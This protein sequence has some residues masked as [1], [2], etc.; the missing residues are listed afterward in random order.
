MEFNVVKSGRCGKYLLLY[1]HNEPN[2]PSYVDI[3]R[4]KHIGRYAVTGEISEYVSLWTCD[5][6]RIRIYPDIWK[7]TNMQRKDV[8]NEV[9]TNVR[10][11]TLSCY[12]SDIVTCLGGLITN[13]K[14]SFLIVL[15]KILNKSEKC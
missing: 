8:I 14:K 12:L 11:S 6:I 10:R 15:E 7:L 4:V 1:K 3:S 5:N 13:L 9:I 2:E